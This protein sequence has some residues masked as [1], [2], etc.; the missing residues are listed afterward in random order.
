[1]KIPNLERMNFPGKYPIKKI[2]DERGVSPVIAVILMVAITVV[3]AAVLYV[4]VIGII[5]KPVPPLNGAMEFVETDSQS[6]TY[7][8]SLISINRLVSYEDVSVTI[9]DILSGSSASL[10]PLSNEGSAS[11]GTDQLSLMYRDVNNNGKLDAAD[12]F[13][14]Q[15]GDEGDIIVLT[16]IKG[17]GNQICKVTLT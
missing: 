1:M 15:N 17:S 11:C 5:G 4:M 16:H 2:F 3:L 8:G 10:S 14:V 12:V 7:I 9:T 13:F 6:G